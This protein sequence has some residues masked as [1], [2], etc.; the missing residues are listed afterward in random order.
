[1]KCEGFKLL[2]NLRNRERFM[3]KEK[4]K[5]FNVGDLVWVKVNCYPWWPSIIYDEALTSSHVQ[6]AK[7]E[8]LM[9]V[10]F[11]GD[12]SYNWLD[13]KKLLHF[14]SNFSLYSNR[15]SS[16]LF[17]KALN[18][19]VYEINH[20]AAL[21]L[22][23]PCQFFS[24]YR[25]A[26]VKGF[27]EVDIDGYS[28][29]GVYSVQQIKGFRQEFKS[30]QTL[31]FI[32]QLALDPTN[33]HQDPSISKEVAR[34]LAFRKAK[35]AEVDEPYFLAFGVHPQRLVDPSI[36]SNQQETALLQAPADD[37]KKPT[38][39]LQKKKKRRLATPK[40]NATK[41]SHK[42]KRNLHHDSQDDVSEKKRQVK[43]E[44]INKNLDIISTTTSDDKQQDEPQP[45]PQ[46][47]AT[48]T[49]TTTITTTTTTTTT[50]CVPLKKRQRRRS[51][52]SI[53]GPKLALV[54]SSERERKKEEKSGISI[55]EKGPKMVLSM[56]FPPDSA[57]PSVSELK[58]KF[59]KFGPMDLS[60]VR[61]SYLKARC[62]V[63]FMNKSDAQK[64]YEHVV[65][66]KNMF[67]QTHVSYRLHPFAN[68]IKEGSKE[69]APVISSH[70]QQQ[71]N[72]ETTYANKYQKAAA[73]AEV[74][75]GS[76]DISEKM[77]YLLNECSRIVFEHEAIL[78]TQKLLDLN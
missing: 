62:Q 56:K 75:Q 55:V 60:G 4:E 15:S 32:Q 44:I 42:V 67:G 23:C 57:L 31:S 78:A 68:S 24:S 5:Q 77:I 49:T 41:T 13:P 34:V 2:S 10:S 66:F 8:G 52:S 40:P 59:A 21:G 7:K 47:E 20:R 70:M 72:Q 11:F 38:V 27:L 26:F 18:E 76:V 12:N 64:A 61:V 71:V 46:P 65:K 1:M 25:P 14:E 43:V 69:T 63:V 58:A 36:T 74:S 37:E 73:G 3:E 53:G 50:K 54:L 48:T 33:V 19:A 16:R 51:V 35:Y 29:G 39:K 9:L 45:Q 30:L 6:Q 17:L 28:T 22:T